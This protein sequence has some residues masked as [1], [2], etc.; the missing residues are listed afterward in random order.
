MIQ[1]LGETD[2]DRVRPLFQE[3]IA[4]NAA[5]PALLDG[6]NHGWILVDDSE[7]PTCAF[8]SAVEGSYLAGDPTN[9]AFVEAVNAYLKENY[10]NDDLTVDGGAIYMCVHPDDWEGK[11]AALFHPREPFI[12]PRRHYLCTELQYTDWRDRIPEGFSV[13]RVDDTFLDAPGIDIPD[14]IFSWIKWNW[15]SL[16]NYRNLGFGFCTMY[17]NTVVSWSLADCV[18]NDGRCEIGIQT[19]PDYRRQGLAAIT[20]AAGVDHALNNGFTEVGWQCNEDNVGSYKTA[21]RVGFSHER[22][23]THHYCMFS[24][25]HQL[26][27]KA[28]YA[29][30]NGHPPA[31]AVESYERLFA[32]SDD[33]PDYIYHVAALANAALGNSEKAIRYLN[34]AVDRDW[35]YSEFTEECEEFSILHGTPEWEAVLKR[36]QGIETEA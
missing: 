11:V 33:F 5:L 25:V 32:L 16:E 23:Y 17:E 20:A 10:F 1:K 24:S 35:S 14:H 18:T 19:R 26:V 36:M 28:W 6:N 4:Y 30:R 9:D 31:E 21:E 15:E 22:D 29:Y 34:A 3:L 8:A 7:N 27:E 12:L 13:R 2:Y